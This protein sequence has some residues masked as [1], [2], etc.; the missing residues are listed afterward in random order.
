MSTIEYTP[1]DLMTVDEVILKWPRI[2]TRNE[3]LL[4]I[5]N[6]SIEY[7]SKGRTRLLARQS[8]NDYIKRHM[9]KTCPKDAKNQFSNSVDFGLPGSE[10]QTPST[11]TGIPESVKES[12]A[13]VLALQILKRPKPSL[14]AM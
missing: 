2:F 6:G 3:L 11:V 4:A 12:A 10:V 7:C 5:R 9:V 8:I 1:D 13:K 14:L